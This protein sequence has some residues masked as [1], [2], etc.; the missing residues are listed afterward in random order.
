MSLRTAAWL[1][2]LVCAHSLMLTA[3]GL[4]L[5]AFDLSQPDTLVYDYWVENTILALAFSVVGGVVASRRPGDPIGWLFCSVGFIGG[6]R[7]LSSEYAIHALLAKPGSLPGGLAAAWVSS[8]VW[9]AH[10]GLM[11][12]L[13]L[14]FPDGQLPSRRWRSLA[15]IVVSVVLIGTIAMALSPGPIDGLYH[16]S[17]GEITVVDAS[18]VRG[19][20]RTSRR[21][22]PCRRRLQRRRCETSTRPRRW[23][24]SR[25]RSPTGSS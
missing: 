16:L 19:R 25:P 21:P 20:P 24:A 14:L 8:W 4:L 11:V 5:V 15:R 9:V 12:F 17:R 1:A 6:I 10:V 23:R 13:A 3:F 22:R 2:W 18:I 7:L